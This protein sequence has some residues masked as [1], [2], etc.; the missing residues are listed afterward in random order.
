MRVLKVISETMIKELISDIGSRAVFL[1]YWLKN[2]AE[3]SPSPVNTGKVKYC[4]I[5]YFLNNNL[6]FPILLI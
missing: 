2:F 3:S 6:M 1:D 4:N 5:L